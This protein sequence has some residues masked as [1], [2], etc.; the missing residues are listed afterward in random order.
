MATELAWLKLEGHDLEDL[1]DLFREQIDLERA[2]SGENMDRI[3]RDI[4][5]VETRLTRLTDAFIDE[6]IDKPTFDERRAEL[7]GKKRDLTDRLASGEDSTFWKDVA[8]KFEL[9][10]AANSDYILAEEPEKRETVKIFGSNLIADG[11]KPGFPM[12]FPFNDIREWSKLHYG[13]PTGNRT[14]ISCVKGGRP[15]R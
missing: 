14:P 13:D 15:N 5:L 8:E 2:A 10:L 1:R 3:R 11:K 12:E 9:G 7:L 4:G 6:M